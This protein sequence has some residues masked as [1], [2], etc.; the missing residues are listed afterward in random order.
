[1]SWARH[2]QPLPRLFLEPFGTSQQGN[3]VMHSVYQDRT[4][5]RQKVARGNTTPCRLGSPPSGRPWQGELRVA[6]SVTEPGGCAQSRHSEVS[7]VPE[8]MKCA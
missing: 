3:Y 7:A 8:R 2:T 5:A 6:T 4:T 1:M